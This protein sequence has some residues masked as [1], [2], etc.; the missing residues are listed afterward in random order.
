MSKH[1]KENSPRS[2][3]MAQLEPLMPKNWRLVKYEDNSDQP[4][5]VLIKVRMR[6]VSRMKE[7][8]QGYYS[9][10]AVLE[11]ITPETNPTKAEDSLDVVLFDLLD[12]LD[13]INPN[14]WDTTE[15]VIDSGT[16]RLAYDVTINFVTQ[17]DAS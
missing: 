11:L 14:L 7:A 17:K 9:T 3:L 10:Q 8:P 13:A 6:G 15:K 16:K 4:D 5:R 1:T 12:I 2:Q